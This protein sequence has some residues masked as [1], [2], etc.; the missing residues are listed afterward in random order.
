MA[1]SMKL[2]QRRIV[3][4]DDIITVSV[5]CVRDVRRLEYRKDLAKYYKP[6]YG[7]IR[8][9]RTNYAKCPGIL[10]IGYRVLF[11]FAVLHLAE[12]RDDPRAH[13]E[14][15][16]LCEEGVVSC[17][18]AIDDTMIDEATILERAAAVRIEREADEHLRNIGMPSS[19][20]IG[21]EGPGIRECRVMVNW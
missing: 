17:D 8:H 10:R 1:T 7:V 18:E 13:N 5:Y 14:R 12:S 21:R 4:R 3:I 15:M 9:L 19:N 16:V 2:K 6:T 20:W 11:P